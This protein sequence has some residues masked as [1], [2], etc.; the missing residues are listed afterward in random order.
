MT[1][2]IFTDGA[3]KGNPGKAG[4][5]AVIF[6]DGVEIQRLTKFLG[7]KTNNEAE[8]SAVILALEAVKTLKL[9]KENILLF[10]DSEFLVRQLKG[11]YAVKAEK[12]K[13]L[14]DA[15][16]SLRKGLQIK[17]QW[18][19]R[20]NNK[21]ADELAN[22]AISDNGKKTQNNSTK[23]LETNIMTESKTRDD[24][25]S[26]KKVNTISPQVSSR[27]SSP[28]SLLIDEAFFGKIN[29]LKIQFNTQKE[30]YFHLGLDTKG[31]WDWQKVKMSNNELGEI[32]WL[33]KRDIGKCAFFH[34]F[35]TSKTQIW[36]NKS[37]KGFSI[38]VDKV[39]KNLSIGEAEVLRVLLEEIIKLSI[40]NS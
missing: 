26:Q 39:S 8:Y 7:E 10:S 4:A 38:K 33:L 18:V 22:K 31:K 25:K 16:N 11:E 15:V 9:E 5:G 29:C 17:F 27:S 24:A 13:P 19:P 40:I 28:T 21:I 30:C 12:I 2:Q 14:Y 6:Q 36:C 35:G 1:L 23:S 20:D 34:S 3:S 32:I 37:E